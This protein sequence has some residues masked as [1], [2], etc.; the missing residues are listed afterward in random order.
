MAKQPKPESI[1]QELVVE[2]DFDIDGWLTGVKTDVKPG[3]EEAASRLVPVLIQAAREGVTRKPA[4]GGARFFEQIDK[5]LVEQA[6]G[7][8]WRPQ[9]VQ[10]VRG[11]FDQFKSILGDMPLSELKHEALN[12]LR[13]TLCWRRPKIDQ[14]LRVVPDEN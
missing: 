6:R 11:D 2:L 9:T 10:D 5:Y 7:A 1:S 8:D 3:E 14:F 12:K 13:D 4:G